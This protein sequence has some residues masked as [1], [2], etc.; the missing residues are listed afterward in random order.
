M[1]RKKIA[2]LVL[3]IP[4]ARNT[5][6]YQRIKSLSENFELCLLTNHNFL[7]DEFKNKVN[8]WVNPFRN[9]PGN[10]YLFILWSIWQLIKKRKEIKLIITSFN[11]STLV[12]AIF[13]KKFLNIKW[14]ADIY[15]MPNLQTET[16]SGRGLVKTIKSMLL[17]FQYFI[18]KKIL[19]NANLVFCTLHPD[20]LSEYDIPKN[21]VIELTNGVDLTL[22]ENFFKIQISNK[23][24][25]K[26]FRILYVGFVLKIRGIDIIIKAANLLKEKYP[27]IKW[28]LIGPSNKYDVQWFKEREIT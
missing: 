19:K 4:S 20:A 7:P 5:T 22:V 2:Y 26:F 18:V 14:V 28:K 24:K 25:E 8:F 21:K 1:D 3:S 12:P 15:D 13:L 23:E 9:F 16:L 10:S 27:L 6:R 17:K 11:P